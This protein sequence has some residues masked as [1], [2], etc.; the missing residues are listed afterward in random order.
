MTEDTVFIPVKIVEMRGESALVEW[1]LKRAI[2]PA[3]VIHDDLT[4][5]QDELEMGIPYGI[6]W[7]N[8]TLTATSQAL[9]D[10]LRANG[11]WTRE[12][13]ERNPSAAFG[14]LQAVYGVDLAAIYQ[15]AY[16]GK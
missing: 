15:A 6:P 11:I 9:A 4:V 5:S 2:I 13:L 16:G 10:H 12:D 3:S 7:E 14:A 8:I 1:N